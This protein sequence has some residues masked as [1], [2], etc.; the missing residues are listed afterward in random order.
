MNK[1]EEVEKRLYKLVVLYQKDKAINN[2]H[3]K[4]ELA[5]ILTNVYMIQIGL[6]ELV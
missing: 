3:V 5:E 2:Q 4:K 6:K 1:L